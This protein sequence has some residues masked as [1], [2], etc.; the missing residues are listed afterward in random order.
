MVTEADLLRIK[1]RFQNY[2][3][4]FYTGDESFDSAIRLKEEHTA[5]VMVEILDIANSMN[6]KRGW[7]YCAEIVAC[8]HDIGRFEQFARYRTYAD[9]KSEDHALLGVKTLDS[10]D[11]LEGVDPAAREVIREV[12]LNHNRADLPEK[13]NPESSFFLMALRDADKI[14]ILRVVTRHYCGL[15]SGDTIRL[16]LPDVPAVSK[17]VVQSVIRGEIVRNEDVRTFNDLKLLQLGWVFDLN[18]TRSFEKVRER[19]YIDKIAAVLPR[20]G[21]VERAIAAARRHLERNCIFERSDCGCP[22]P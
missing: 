18:Y 9:S 16:G 8:L 4:R 12:V 17:A 15:D 21:G 13:P 22:T 11:I 1:Q 19:M 6:I 3:R 2:V 20:T 14:D 10:S 7:C 5:K